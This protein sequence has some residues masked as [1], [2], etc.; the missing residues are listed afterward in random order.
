MC[1]FRC[2]F[3]HICVFLSAKKP[4]NLV[5]TIT[6]IILELGWTYFE[7][8]RDRP[9]SKISD[10]LFPETGPAGHARK[11]LAVVPEP[12]VRVAATTA[13]AAF[14]VQPDFL[15]MIATTDRIYRHRP[16][17]FSVHVDK[18]TNFRRSHERNNAREMISVRGTVKRFR[19]ERAQT[20]TRIFSKVTPSYFVCG[21]S[22]LASLANGYAG[23]MR[24]RYSAVC[25]RQRLRARDV[26]SDRGR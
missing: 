24:P 25:G 17:L 10:N 12:D 8:N 9:E 20:T 7:V 11:T 26:Y 3:K 23:V 5:T 19:S 21:G 15:T 18:R 14:I 22:S 2:F 13:A 6:T 16:S 4:L 1:I